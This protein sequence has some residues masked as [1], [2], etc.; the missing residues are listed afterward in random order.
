MIISLEYGSY[1]YK[2]YDV[3]LFMKESSGRFEIVFFT[4]RFSKVLY[5]TSER[6]IL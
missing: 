1:K 4:V 6:L 3:T 5:M 2:E